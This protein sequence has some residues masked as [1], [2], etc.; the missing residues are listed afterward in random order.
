[1]VPIGV[2]PDPDSTLEQKKPDSEPTT[3]K[4]WI[5]LRPNQIK[6]EI[7]SQYE[8]QSNREISILSQL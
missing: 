6:V 7:F 2:D 5:R 4:N 1:M 3:M 8:K